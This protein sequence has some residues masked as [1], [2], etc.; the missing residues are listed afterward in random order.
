[1][2]RRLYGFLRQ[3]MEHLMMDKEQVLAVLAQLSGESE[4][5]PSRASASGGFSVAK[6]PF[7]NG[8]KPASCTYRFHPRIGEHDRVEIR[9]SSGYIKPLMSD[10]ALEQWTVYMSD[11][12][13]K[14]TVMAVPH[15]HDFHE[16]LV[17]IVVRQTFVLNDIDPKSFISE[18]KGV[19]MFWQRSMRA[20][21][22]RTVAQALRQERRDK[23]DEA[24]AFLK[25]NPRRT[26][27]IPAPG[28]A[29]LDELNLLVGL[30]NLKDFARNLM[31]QH[32][33]AQLRRQNGL[34]AVLPS[35]HLVFVGNPG[36]GKTTVVEI[37]GRLYKS[38]GLLK[39]GHVVVA[40][41]SNLVGP[42]IG[43]TAIR[44]REICEKALGGILFID[45]AYSLDVNG[46]DFGQE[47]IE[48]LLTFMEAHRDE[49][50]IIV[51]G[52]PSEMQRFLD[53]N[54]GLRSRFDQVIHFE[55]FTHDELLIM[56]DNLV[57]QNDYEL[58]STAR[59]EVQA[60]LNTW[61]DHENCGNARDVR[62]LFNEIVNEHAVSLRGIKTPTKRQL[63]MLTSLSIPNGLVVNT[64]VLTEQWPR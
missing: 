28:E 20:L 44:T 64:D 42:Y 19:L 34:T 32:H 13:T 50:V 11:F 63:K 24:I 58:T 48:T 8:P 3:R 9:I 10:E 36:T 45:E 52:Y 40:D 49:M 37:M 33:I 35:P 1:M 29:A 47:A 41:R 31:R 61:R 54:P 55:D 62:S 53:S 43:Q 16:R 59:A 15:S 6:F 27:D 57:R 56:F 2:E 12:A 25:N 18:I 22:M 26:T 30:E 46:R 14:Y 7:H 60:I 17:S 4:L 38:L 23:T 51:A 5:T 21:E 39:K